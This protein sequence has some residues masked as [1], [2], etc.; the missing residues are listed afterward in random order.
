MPVPAESG[1]GTRAP[2]GKTAD[3][4]AGKAEKSGKPA[5]PGARTRGSVPQTR[6]SRGADLR[7]SRP[8]RCRPARRRNSLKA[9]SRS[10]LALRKLRDVPPG[11]HTV[12]LFFASPNKDASLARRILFRRIADVLLSMTGFGEAHSQQDGLAV[13]VEVRAINS[14]FFKLSVRATEGYAS[15]EPH[16]EEI[17]R[18]NIRRGTVQVNLRVDRLRSCQDFRI[19]SDVLSGYRDQLQALYR[20]WDRER[21]GIAGGLAAPARR[22]ERPVDPL[23]PRGRLAG[24]LQGLASGAAEPGPDADPRRPGHGR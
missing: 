10:F 17:T 9:W 7:R 19:N 12:E 4:A 2:A 11:A 21:R 22:G 18:Q 23:Q 1:A 13:A 24:D 5:V 6:E 15:L 14:R 16:I 8:C 20:K 3:S